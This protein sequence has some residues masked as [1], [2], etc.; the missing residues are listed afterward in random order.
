MADGSQA[1]TPPTEPVVSENAGSAGKA[2]DGSESADIK[3]SPELV[4]AW[5]AKA[6]Q[7]N[8]LKRQVQTLSEQLR[9]QQSRSVTPPT[10]GMDSDTQVL[11]EQAQMG[12]PLAKEAL[13]NRF[14]RG[15]DEQV[16]A[17]NVPSEYVLKVKGII[18]QSNYNTSVADAIR[19]ARGGEVDT[20]AEQLKEQ[21]EENERLRREV[22]SSKTRVPGTSATVVPAAGA[23]LESEES[24][25]HSQ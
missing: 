20:L 5:K 24:I 8:E 21:R 4:S 23:A 12:N 18:R 22:E 1:G 11:I 14:E 10:S 9:E 6:E 17:H 13:I 25:A 7:A 2:A 19:M 16:V 3:A 15:L